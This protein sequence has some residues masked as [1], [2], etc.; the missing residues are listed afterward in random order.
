VYNIVYNYNYWC[1][2]ITFKVARF[3][4]LPTS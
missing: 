4:S 2:L 3:N 1:I